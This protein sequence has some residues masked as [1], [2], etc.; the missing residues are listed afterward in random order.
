MVYVISMWML[1]F[2]TRCACGSKRDRDL[3]RISLRRLWQPQKKKRKWKRK[4]K[5]LNR[6]YT[7]HIPLLWQPPWP[8]RYPWSRWLNS[9]RRNKPLKS[10]SAS[11][12][13]GLVTS[14]VG[15][16][17]CICWKVPVLISLISGKLNF[18]SFFFFLCLYVLKA[19]GDNVIY[20]PSDQGKKN[21]VFFM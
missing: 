19:Q 4:K 18:L 9:Q 20:F 15:K 21:L 5:N 6:Q 16:C 13:S 12:Q 17:L 2:R 1:V 14:R 3:H 10:F 7:C 11:A 8:G